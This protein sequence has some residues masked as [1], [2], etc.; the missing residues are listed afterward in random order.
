MR[1]SLPLALFFVAGA[2]SPYEVP[3]ARRAWLES[4]GGGVVLPVYRDFEARTEVLRDETEA[5]CEMPDDGSLESARGA[6]WEAR[7][8]LKRGDAFAFGPYSD[9]PLR[10]GPK[11]DFWPA[12]PAAIEG[13]LASTLTLDDEGPTT[14]GA[15]EKGMPAIEYLLYE[16]NADL[17]AELSDTPRRCEYL[18]AL[19]EDLRVRAT[20]LRA[21]WDPAGDDYLGELVGAGRTS[22]RYASLTLAVSAVLQELGVS[23][24]AMRIDRLEKPLGQ[25]PEGSAAPDA[26]ESR[27]S[28]RSLADL[29]DALD[30]VSL[31]YFGDPAGSG[32]GRYL[33]SRG[34]DFDGVMTERLTAARAAVEA[35]PEPLTRA[36]SE[37]PRDVSRAVDAL[38]ALGR[39]VQIEMVNALALSVGFSQ[40]DGD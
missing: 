34:H 28:G 16:P 24:E 32:L 37:S 17:V 20:E 10:L 40:N 30:G 7:A 35:V 39:L 14:L 23:L 3:D 1:R 27:F 4:F 33:R 26:A 19:T 36:V 2:C 11:I 12:R 5:L 29:G 9:E 25:A 31:V 15:A 8:P 13:V 22:S 38:A 21:A 6:W 18:L